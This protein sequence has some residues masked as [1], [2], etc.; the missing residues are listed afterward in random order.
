MTATDLPPVRGFRHE[1]FLYS[2]DGEF[3]DGVT[4]FARDGVTRGD[5]VLVVVDARKIDRL[6]R[7]LDGAASSV[8]FADMQEVG[9]NPALIV[10]AWRDFVRRYGGAG[11]ALR[12]VGE[13]VSPERSPAALTEC[14][15]HEAVLNTA[16][17]AEPDFW[18][19]CPYDTDALS[20]SDVARAVGNHPYVR[21]DGG[22]IA[23][24]VAHSH[25]VNILT[26]ELPPPPAAAERF[27]F[28]AESIHDL[29]EAVAR[30]ARSAGVGDDGVA[31]LVI[32]VS[33]IATN[34]VVHGHGRG[35]ATVWVADDDFLCDLHGPGRITDPMVG[36]LRPSASQMHGY[37]I[38][39]ANQFCDLVQIR[40]REGGTTVRLHVTRDPNR[41]PSR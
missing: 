17:G 22:L 30:R 13:P 39:L 2:G 36:R 32:A 3:L 12:G 25:A 18:L 33:E 27:L 28:G 40:S 41:S 1:A 8:E 23:H 14:H 29:R 5:A 35:I 20:D 4:R 6:R 21:G 15:I 7:A 31:G 26:S 11:R 24:D 34:T 37:G 38:W 16:F 9:R 10:Q 19:L